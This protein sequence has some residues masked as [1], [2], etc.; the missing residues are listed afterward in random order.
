MINASNNV[1]VFAFVNGGETLPTILLRLNRHH[2]DYGRY[3]IMNAYSL[4]RVYRLSKE[5]I[6]KL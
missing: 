3:I 5:G 2:T 1:P 6:G 4:F